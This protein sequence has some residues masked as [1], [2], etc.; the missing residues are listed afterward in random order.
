MVILYFED[1]GLSFDMNDIDFYETTSW[2]GEKPT[3]A[4][5]WLFGTVFLVSLY[6]VNV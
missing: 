1:N 5:A 6:R 3:F 4:F 2:P